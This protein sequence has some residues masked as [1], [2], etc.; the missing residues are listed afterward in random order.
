MSRN[1][2]AITT[3][4]DQ[5][6]IIAAWGELSGTAGVN[7]QSTNGPSNMTGTLI[8]GTDIKIVPSY[9]S[10][11]NALGAKGYGAGVIPTG[12]VLLEL[13][14][15][16]R[17]TNL[18]YWNVDL[19]FSGTD[20]RANGLSNIPQFTVEKYGANMGSGSFLFGIQAT[21][22]TLGLNVSS[23]QNTNSG[24]YV[25]VIPEDRINPSAMACKWRFFAVVRDSKR[26]T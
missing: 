15:N 6:S 8:D 22:S 25:G 1:K 17:Y 10:G 14:L 3:T 20:L 4:K 13:P 2:I 7:P 19:E 24:S 21:R 18:I 26:S 16:N 11:S 23:L 12:S 5:V 9:P